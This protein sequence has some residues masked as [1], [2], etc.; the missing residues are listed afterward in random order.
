[1]VGKLEE[2]VHAIKTPGR[3]NPETYVLTHIRYNTYMVLIFG[4]L[5]KAQF[6]KMPFKV[7][8]HDEI[9]ILMSFKYLNVF[10]PNKHT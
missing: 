9:E 2:T 7:S 4:D 3:S 10:K 6:Y 5:N 8:W 1:M